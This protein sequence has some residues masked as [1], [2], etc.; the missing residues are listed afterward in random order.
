MA[1]IER[2]QVDDH[3]PKWLHSRFLSA[4]NYIWQVKGNN[5]ESIK[6]VD[7][8]WQSGQFTDEEMSW[9]MLLLIMPKVNKMIKETREW[10]DFQ[11]MKKESVH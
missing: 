1:K 3:L 5:E 8:V 9:I 2:R 11:E 10:Q 4:V 6:R 7:D